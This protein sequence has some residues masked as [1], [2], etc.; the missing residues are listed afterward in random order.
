VFRS[1][2]NSKS[3]AKQ[4]RDS[5]LSTISLRFGRW[6]RGLFAKRECCLLARDG[7]EEG[8]LREGYSM[9]ELHAMFEHINLK[10]RTSLKVYQ[11]SGRK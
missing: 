10:K 2:N 3:D 4:R 7:L 1:S 8:L 6:N 5:S 9:I 11:H